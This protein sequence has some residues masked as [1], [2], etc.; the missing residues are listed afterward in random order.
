MSVRRR[1][2]LRHPLT[3]HHQ[4]ISTLERRNKMTQDS[5]Q[6]DWI[7]WEETFSQSTVA[8]A[9]SGRYYLPFTGDI[10]EA[11]ASLKTA[12]SS[13]T[14]VVVKID[15]GTQATINLAA[16]DQFEKALLAATLESDTD[17]ATVETTA[18]GTGAQGLVVTLRFRRRAA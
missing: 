17:Y 5:P 7:Y 11:V 10:Y 18:A 2:S 9:A 1:D 6:P 16:S 14:T 8:V 13:T 12:G 4:R 3:S 15:G